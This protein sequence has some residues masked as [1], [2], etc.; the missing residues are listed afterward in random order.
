MKSS[1]QVPRISVGISCKIWLLIGFCLRMPAIKASLFSVGERG[2]DAI[3][4]NIL[5]LSGFHSL[6]LS[7]FSSI[8]ALSL[9]KES[10][11]RRNK[12]I[13]IRGGEGEVRKIKDHTLILSR[14]NL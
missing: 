14:I 4:C 6:G 2:D 10:E 8:K 13:D 5:T 11:G 1:D 12:V 3:C 9:L 7:N